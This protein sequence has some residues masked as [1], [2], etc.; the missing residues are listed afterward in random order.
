M[1]DQQDLRSSG[2]DKN[3]PPASHRGA[4]RDCHMREGRSYELCVV[5]APVAAG[6]AQETPARLEVVQARSQLHAKLPVLCHDGVQAYELSLL[7]VV[8]CPQAAIGCAAARKRR[9]AGPDV[10][11]RSASGARLGPRVLQ[12]A[13]KQA[14]EQDQYD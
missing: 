12:G 14:Q 2:P 6:G 10:R 9:H 4:L 3:Q 7:E 5:P 13:S 1:S 8:S 11:V